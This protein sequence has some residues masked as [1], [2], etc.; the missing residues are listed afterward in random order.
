MQQT[1]VIHSILYINNIPLQLVVIQVWEG[2]FFCRQPPLTPAGVAK[3]F[4]MQLSSPQLST[5][6]SFTTLFICCHRS[7]KT[8][9]CAGSGRI[10]GSLQLAST[11]IH[12][13][14]TGVAQTISCPTSSWAGG[15][16]SGILQ[17]GSANSCQ[18]FGGFS[19]HTRSSFCP[20][21]TF[22]GNNA[23]YCKQEKHGSHDVEFACWWSWV[24]LLCGGRRKC[25]GRNDKCKLRG[26]GTRIMPPQGVYVMCPDHQTHTSGCKKSNDDTSASPISMLYIGPTEGATTLHGEVPEPRKNRQSMLSPPTTLWCFFIVRCVNLGYGKKK[27]SSVKWG[28]NQQGMWVMCPDPQTHCRLSENQV[29]AA[30]HDKSATPAVYFGPTEGFVIAFGKDWWRGVGW[31][32]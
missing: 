19:S 1:G 12:S 24:F 29:K 22:L 10:W 21:N 9:I 17:M 3:V 31:C 18:S 14:F 4:G 20:Q 16:S 32:W 8:T 30:Y 7:H 5:D 11:G 26:L 28:G 23:L 2:T 13:Q 6:N 25:C 15:I 27:I